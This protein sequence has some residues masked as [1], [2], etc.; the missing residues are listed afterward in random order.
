MTLISP[1]KKSPNTPYMRAACDDR[2]WGRWEVIDVGERFCVKRITVKPGAKLSLQFHYHRHEHWTV[3]RGTARVT[4]GD[5]AF[6]LSENES[7]FIPIGTAHRVENP[8]S[9]PLELIEVQYGEYLDE[10]DI[11]R[12]EDSYGRL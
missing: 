10:D 5:A 12:L 8:G 11:V 7:T 3:V 1:V 4:K 6:L 9:L 2:P